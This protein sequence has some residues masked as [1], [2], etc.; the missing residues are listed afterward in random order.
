PDTPETPAYFTYDG[1]VN[2]KERPTLDQ[3]LV[4]ELRPLSLQEASALVEEGAELLDTRDP[5]DFAGAHIA[6][7]LNVG[8]SGAYATWAGTILDSERPVVVVADPGR[9]QEASMRLGRIG[10]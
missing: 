6:G 3:T 2:T 8:L 9:E 4:D 5:A 1:V 10:F 7:S